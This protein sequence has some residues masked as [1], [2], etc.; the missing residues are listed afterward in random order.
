[1]ETLSSSETSVSTGTT[2]RNF[3]EDGFLQSHRRE[4]PNYYSLLFFCLG[5]FISDFHSIIWL[6]SI[7]NSLTSYTTIET[8]CIIITARIMA[9][10][11]IDTLLVTTCA[12]I[13]EKPDCLNV[14]EEKIIVF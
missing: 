7:S 11:N 12:Q 1:M 6:L 4:T 8:N 3:P 5:K 10:Q 13:W 14:V 2:E 9:C